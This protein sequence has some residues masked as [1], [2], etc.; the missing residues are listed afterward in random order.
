[1]DCVQCSVQ[2][3][4]QEGNAV[5]KT[6]PNGGNI[7]IWQCRGRTHMHCSPIHRS[8][9]R[10]KF[11]FPLP[12]PSFFFLLPARSLLA[13]IVCICAS[14]FLVDLHSIGCRRGLLMLISPMP[15]SHF[16][17]RFTMITMSNGTVKSQTRQLLEIDSYI[18]EVK[19]DFSCIHSHAIAP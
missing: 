4:M 18:F 8:P 5:R 13:S 11:P 17:N 9:A 12:S 7:G 19:V 1:M 14:S 6:R 3:A 15:R 2:Y 16:L 10:P